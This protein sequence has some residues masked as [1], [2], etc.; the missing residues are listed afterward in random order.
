MMMTDVKEIFSDTNIL[1]YAT[2]TQSPW[3]SIA[4][5]AL[6]KTRT[7]NIE[8]IVSTQI[9][10]E[11]LAAATRLNA[12]GSE[13]PLDKI[14]ENIQSFRE[15][16]TVVEDN[17]LAVL[18]KLVDL[19]QSTSTAGKQIHDANIVATMLVHG[20]DHL[21]T[22]NITDFQRFSEFIKILPLEKWGAS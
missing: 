3:Q 18:D 14:L 6:Q 21:L 8:L 11:Y 7:Q 16:F 1:I 13:M 20:I 17:Q 2:N 5:Q 10:R 19:V 15:N 22:H 4:K 12:T 9:L